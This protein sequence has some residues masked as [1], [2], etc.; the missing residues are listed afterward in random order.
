MYDIII[1]RIIHIFI[2]IFIT[3][4]VA[5][6]IALLILKYNIEGEDN[7]PFELSSIAVFSKADGIDIEEQIEN[8]R[9]LQI[10]QNNDIYLQISKNKNY[11][12]TEI[13]DEVIIDNFKIDEAPNVGTVKLYRPTQNG[14]EKLPYENTEEN[15][16]KE[17]LIYK[18]REKSSVKNLEIANQGGQILFRYSIENLGIY[19]TNKDV[20]Q[21][22]HLLSEVNVAYENLQCKMSFDLS[23]KLKSGIIYTGKITLD[24]PA[25][26][27]MQDG[28]SYYEITDLKDIIFRRNLR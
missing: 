13:I 10:A 2:A 18:G 23:I 3:I 28:I 24:F 27:V 8:T 22:G 20:K 17:S 15:E 21:D 4:L 1:K 12:E 14:N 11:E 16:I 25:G 19:D 5:T 26:N 6:I 7:M 9:K